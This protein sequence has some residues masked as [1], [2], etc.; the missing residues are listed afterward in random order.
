MM[1]VVMDSSSGDLAHRLYKKNVEL[2][3]GLR[4]SAQS[5]TP[6]DPNAW[7]QMRENYEV[8]ILEDHD[9]SEKHEIEHVLWQLHY[10]RIQEFR[11]RISAAASTGSVTSQSGKAPSRPDNAKK[12]RSLFK[13]FLS[14]ATGFYHD[15][16]LKIRSKYGLPL[17]DF[18]DG[19]VGQT[20][21]TKDEKKSSEMKK[22]LL[23]CHR[24]LI[25]LGDLARYKALYGE[26][27]SISRDYAAASSYYLQA[28]S[29]WPSSG[30]PHH[31]LAILASYSGD[32][33][34]A[35]YRYFRSLATVSPFSRV[36]DNLIIAFEK[37]RHSYSELPGNAK[38]TPAST[39]P[40][41]STSSERGRA[42]GDASYQ[43]KE[44]K[45][46]TNEHDRSIPDILKAFST[47]FV[48]YNGILFT[49]T[50][51]ENFED[52]FSS[53]VSD[54][55]ELLSSG[56]EEELNF[57][58]DAAVNGL[59][60]VRL[61]TILIFTVHNVKRE[62][63]G[64]SYAEILQRTML[65]QNATTCAFLFA[66]YIVKR[67]IQ[68]RD[69][70]SSYLVPAIS[71]FIEW[72]ACHPDIAAS[73]DFEDKQSSARSFFWNQ[74]VS[75]LNKLM[76]TGLVSSDGN[77]DENCFF[78]M[79]R[80][81]EGET[82]NRVAL[83]EDFELRGFLPLIA[84]HGILDFSRKHSFG[85]DG[86][87]SE[88]KARMQRILAAGRALID[89]VRID[90]QGIYFDQNKKQFVIGVNPVWYSDQIS[91][92]SPL[93]SDSKASKE[94]LVDLGVSRLNTTR[95]EIAA[96]K[97]HSHVEGDEEEEIVFKPMVIEKYPKSTDSKPTACEL[98]QPVQISSIGD[99][100]TYNAPLLA[101]SNNSQMSTFANSSSQLQT[102]TPNVSQ[103]SLQQSI[104]TSKWL[105]EQEPVLSER[106][107]SLKLAGNGLQKGF[108]H[109]QPTVFSSLVSAPAYQDNIRMSYREME[110]AE[111][112]IPS[113]LDS[114]IHQGATTSDGLRLSVGSSLT[115][116]KNPVS[117]PV[118]HRGPPPG[119]DRFPTKLV[120]DSNLNSVR[121]DQYCK[122]DD[123]RWQN[124]YQSLTT[125]G[126]G[127]TPMN[128]AALH[129]NTSTST[130]T[131]EMSFPF[132]GK[133][134]FTTQSRVT[135]KLQ[136]PQPFGH[137]QPLSDQQL[138][139]ANL[140]ASL[141]AEQRRAQALWS[142]R[143]FV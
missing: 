90:Q 42:R 1:T 126:M 118:R 66:G 76:Q 75:F 12:I 9:F 137:F 125:S 82:G 10:R 11:A 101:T 97:V 134:V 43:V 139:Q 13:G 48:R 23:S 103:Q 113:K 59:V 132:P 123:Y 79:G 78:D 19:L 128:D 30:N 34:G 2:E 35:V 81:D 77:E 136:D 15:M 106:I 72:L 140:Q 24:C 94:G 56:P 133:Q 14:E 143:D 84:A 64:Q 141:L 119:F 117:R 39:L 104:Y 120:N 99:C 46:P 7:S 50:S 17:G 62:S 28:T 51:L 37:N 58:Q 47:R 67:C 93:T 22:G 70:S 124:G 45:S 71:I 27:D 36:R 4:K 20:V 5:K 57:G 116:R 129:F 41:P 88:R 73:R 92:S 16:I 69:V 86:N 53:V 68:L 142:S 60:L 107:C 3:N 110:V 89:V 114:V 111:P 87:T 61:V 29:L 25:Y 115:S 8:I 26:G 44:S 6:S 49:G 21:L 138:Q 54:L 122:V 131:G 108:N 55:H 32:E 31:Q 130:F 96:L 80:Y 63:D 83:W 100:T 91:T 109:F 74:F 121:E 105:M 112:V 135:E 65:L 127:M 85:N 40:A 18:S 38:V 52:I 33:L 98:I 102:L 95:M